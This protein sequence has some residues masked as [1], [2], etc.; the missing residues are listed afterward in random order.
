MTDAVLTLSQRRTRFSTS[1]ANGLASR[2]L[3]EPATKW[4]EGDRRLT[5]KAGWFATTD[6]LAVVAGPFDDERD[7]EFA[8]AYGLYHAAD[9]PLV[10][11]IPAEERAGRATC[12]RAPWIAHPLE[13]WTYDLPAAEAG[14]PVD[15]VRQKIASPGDVLARYPDASGWA[16]GTDATDPLSDHEAFLGPRASWVE[17][18]TAWAE[19]DSDLAPAHTQSYLSWHC[20][21]G[22]VL[23]I[24]RSRH[25]LTLTGGIHYSAPDKKPRPIP[26][27]G[28]LTGQEAHEL[29]GRAALAAAGLLGGDD[30]GRREHRLQA[31]IAAA[32]PRP[33]GLT[34]KLRR[35]YPAW[36]PYPKP[37]GR[38][39][40][41]FLGSD[42]ANSLRVI[43]TK[44][45]D[46]PML[47]LQG[48]DYWI[49]AMANRAELARRFRL[50]T[51]TPS[52]LIDFVVSK[53]AAGRPAIG[54]YTRAQSLALAPEVGHRFTEVRGWETGPPV[55][56]PDPQ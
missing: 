53:T 30:G 5:R 9:R 41:D 54:P 42:D 6:R 7:V 56:T 45:G 3:K 40:I 27:T 35:E 12:V 15:P 14:E 43:E 39:C 8:L 33:L 19:S 2:A 46:D 51:E 18:L 50:P 23:K 25:G 4:T 36:R 11:V 32:D 17:R 47:V 29:I 21:G 16:Y 34:D 52:V 20:Q 48:L 24:A 26:L 31:A 44:I 49:W 10:L 55:F 22:L 38:A 28:P 37:R 1:V 13:I